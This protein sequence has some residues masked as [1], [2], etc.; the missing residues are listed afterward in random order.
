MLSSLLN[1]SCAGDAG[2]KN[3][4]IVVNLEAEPKTI[5]FIF[6]YK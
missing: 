5:H 3:D 4:A 1:L 2:N 6:N